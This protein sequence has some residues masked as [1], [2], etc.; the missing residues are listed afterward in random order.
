ML[1]ERGNARSLSKG[2]TVLVRSNHLGTAASRKRSIRARR[3]HWKIVP[4][5][6]LCGSLHRA[7]SGL[8]GLGRAGM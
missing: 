6:S 4:L 2:A 7:D 1:A 5:C 8:R 3:Q